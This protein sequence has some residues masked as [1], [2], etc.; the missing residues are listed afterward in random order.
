MADSDE[1]LAPGRVADIDQRSAEVDTF[2]TTV[3][4]FQAQFMI[5]RELGAEDEAHRHAQKAVEMVIDADQ[6]LI[7]SALLTL[8][9][10]QAAQYISSCGGAQAMVD[11]LNA[12][13]CQCGDDCPPRGDDSIDALEKWIRHAT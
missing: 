9:A 11:R 13:R 12:G 7:F 5:A 1:E 4:N 3:I 6:A 2:V 8:T 10:N